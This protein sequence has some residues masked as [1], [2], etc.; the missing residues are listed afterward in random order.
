MRNFFDRHKPISMYAVDLEI[1]NEETDVVEA[2]VTIH[3]SARSRRAAKKYVKENY[4]TKVGR[5]SKV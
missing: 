2:T 4:Q 3:V 1:R 5:S